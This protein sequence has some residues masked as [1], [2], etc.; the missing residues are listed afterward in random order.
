MWSD[1]K[2]KTKKKA[3]IIKRH[4]RIG[5]DPSKVKHLT[6]LEKRVLQVMR[7]NSVN[8]NEDR[9]SAYEVSNTTIV[10]VTL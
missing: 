3:T 9:D 4:N 10:L 7:L 5:G 6:P 2:N 1:W 8:G